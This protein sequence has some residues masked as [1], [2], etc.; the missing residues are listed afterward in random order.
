MFLLGDGANGKSTFLGQLLYVLGEYGQKVGDT[1]LQP[2][3]RSRDYETAMIDL[4]GKR[5][6]VSGE[7]EEGVRWNEKLVK[8]LTGGD[9]VKGWLL[10]EGNITFAPTHTWWI[11]GNHRP[12]VTS[13]GSAFWRR[14]RLVHFEREFGRAEQD[15][16]LPLKLREEAPGIFNWMVQGCLLWQKEGLEPPEA[17]TQQVI[18][19]R[20]QED[21]VG[22]FV[23]NCIEPR[24]GGFVS[25]AQLYSAFTE[26]CTVEGHHQGLGK[27]Q[28][29]RR[30]AEKGYSSDRNSAG[31]ERGIRGIHLVGAA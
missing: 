7:T 16:H 21:I 24:A 15:P 22:L 9:Q 6:I 30:L 14:M 2:G 27:G 26:W 5:L 17:V 1:L 23:Q 3:L 10:Y 29:A 18:A 19:Y 11:A 12:R 13:T 31:T 25:S 8:D 20:A 4:H 28:L